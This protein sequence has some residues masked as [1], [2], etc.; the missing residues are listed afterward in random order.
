MEV[1]FFSFVPILYLFYQSARNNE[2]FKIRHVWINTGDERRD[3]YSYH[4]MVNPNKHNWYGL[5]F[6]KDNHYK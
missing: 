4:F 1:L 6:P 5:R 3:R 2:V